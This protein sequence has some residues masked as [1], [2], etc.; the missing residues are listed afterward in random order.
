MKKYKVIR[1]YSTYRKGDILEANGLLGAGLYQDLMARGFIELVTPE[2]AGGL[3]PVP[4]VKP[5]P[6]LR[7]R[8]KPTPIEVEEESC[9]KQS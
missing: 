9:L 3:A 7:Q 4:S 5:D 2:V 1:A 6:P 8:R